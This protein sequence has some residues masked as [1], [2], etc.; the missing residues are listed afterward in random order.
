MKKRGG[1]TSGQCETQKLMS[2]ISNYYSL[3]AMV[4]ASPPVP[5]SPRSDLEDVKLA[6]AY[7]FTEWVSLAVI[8]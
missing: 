1:G 4:G 7:D 8:R 2:L 6:R 3:T 5:K